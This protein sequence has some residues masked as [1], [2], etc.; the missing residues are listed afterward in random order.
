MV[1]IV[2][3]FSSHSLHSFFVTLKALHQKL[4]LYNDLKVSDTCESAAVVCK[5]TKRKLESSYL[6]LKSGF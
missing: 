5:K 3:Y 4:K 1:N 2:G 6:A